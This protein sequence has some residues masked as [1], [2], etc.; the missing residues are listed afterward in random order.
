MI[1]HA[2]LRLLAGRA[3][4]P[5][6]RRRAGARASACLGDDA[7]ANCVYAPDGTRHRRP[8]CLD[9]RRHV[10]GLRDA[11]HRQQEEGRVH[12]R[13]ACSRSPR[14]T[15]SRSRNST[16]SPSR[17]I[18]G[19]KVEFVDPPSDYW[20]DYKDEIA[21]AALHAAAEDAGEGA[22]RRAR[23]LRSVLFRRL[24][25]ARRTSGHAGRRAG[26]LQARRSRSRRRWTP[27]W[28]RSCSSW[29][30]T[31]AR[32]VAVLGAQFANKI[33]GEMP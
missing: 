2:I 21:D 33:A 4:R 24:L 13:G 28:R 15:S 18:N 7:R 10:L 12:A 11:G 26:G 20:L 8:P 9:L 30:P 29:R 5:C 27:R 25:V 19:K 16:T 17:K 23:N 31:E 1:K 32:S 3:C 14:S 6:R 22:G